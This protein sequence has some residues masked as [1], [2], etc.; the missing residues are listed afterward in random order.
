MTQ[1]LSK[2]ELLLRVRSGQPMTRRQQLQLVGMLSLPA[3]LAQLSHIL[4]EYIDASM[5]GSLGATASA[6]I[7]LVA[8]STWLFHGLCGSLATGFSV[9]VAHRIGASRFD[10]ARKVLRQALSSCLLFS[11]VL[12]VAGSA[13]SPWLPVWL[14]GD[15]QITADASLYFL[16][17]CLALP[18]CL[19]NHLAG[20]MLR[21]SGNMKVP[22]LLNVLMCF[23]DIGFNLL[24]IFPTRTLHLGGIQFTLPGAGLGV[25][26]AAIGTCA[27]ELVTMALMLYF[28]CWRSR[29]LSLTHERGSFRPSWKVVMASLRISLPMGIEHVIFCGAQIASTI[30]VAPLG[31]AAIAANAFGITIESLCYM[32]GYGISDAATTLVGQSLGA[33]RKDL[34]RHFAW[35]SLGVGIFT[36]S[37]MAVVMYASAPWLMSLMTPDLLVQQLS[38]EALRIEAFAEPLYAASIV[39]Y[40]VFVGAGD[41]LIPCCM[42]LASIWVVRITLAFFLAPHFGLNGVWI[43]MA[44]ELSVRGIIFVL[45]M[46]FGNWQGKAV[47]A[48]EQ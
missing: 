18:F 12:L 20:A 37:V 32:P 25:L 46:A 39:C 13:I 33:G 5:V 9:M 35:L 23:M 26:G 41:T 19:L 40:G 16:V 15:D 22:S 1:K 44:I 36:M 11:L 2:D 3:I 7:G 48:M 10:E 27:A 42:N 14:G 6:A 34:C 8:T 43:A 47:R 21:S 24:L 38:V 17:F 28:L 45:R 4:M 29:E 31:T 30:I